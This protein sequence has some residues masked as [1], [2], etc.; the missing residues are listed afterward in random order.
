MCSLLDEIL[1]SKTRTPDQSSKAGT[2]LDPVNEKLLLK[3]RLV[4]A[5]VEI[6]KSSSQPPK[7]KS[8]EEQQAASKKTRKKKSQT[9]ATR[10]EASVK[11]DAT[12]SLPSAQE[13]G[14]AAHAESTVA[15]SSIS[16]SLP[17]V[18]T[19]PRDTRQNGRPK[20]VVPEYPEELDIGARDV[21]KRDLRVRPT[22]IA[23]KAGQQMEVKMV[24]GSEES[25]AYAKEPI[26]AGKE[27][28]AVAGTFARGENYF[29]DITMDDATVARRKAIKI[30]GKNE[31]TE[32]CI[33]I[34]L[35]GTLGTVLWRTYAINII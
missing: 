16:G 30:N 18:T 1:E 23:T 17:S 28:T 31:M 15:D 14:V 5:E 6:E 34:S 3:T 12:T 33:Q 10:H 29:A 25:G 20:K 27:S 32:T 11:P 9:V 24:K 8:G 4:T 22:A 21:P 26:A 35:P 2:T 19:K 7:P 13:T